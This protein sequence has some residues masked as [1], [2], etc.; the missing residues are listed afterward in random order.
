MRG[1]DRN[2]ILH[3]GQY[4]FDGADAV[5]HTLLGSCIAI[6]MW[7]PARRIG[8]M[9]H[10]ALPR[11]DARPAGARP[12]PRY[13]EDCVELFL[14]SLER[15][16]T[17]IREYEVKLFGGGNMSPRHRARPDGDYRAIGDKNAAT[18]FRLLSEAGANI[19]AADVGEF[20]R[21]RVVFDLSS[22][23]VWVKFTPLPE[24]DE[25]RQRAS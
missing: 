7:H 21:R 4:C 25:I 14:A 9:C 22:G 3:A 17:R 19:V 24:L 18:A 23:D 13:A 12:D 16:G 11:P 15:T 2:I 10:F 6:T 20:G 1:R 8:G 5:V